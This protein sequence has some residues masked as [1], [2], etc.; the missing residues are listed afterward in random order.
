MIERSPTDPKI[1]RQLCSRGLVD[2]LIL[3]RLMEGKVTF[4]LLPAVKRNKEVLFK[5]LRLDRSRQQ[6]D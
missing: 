5:L 1:S 4:Y 3:L 6:L 2:Y